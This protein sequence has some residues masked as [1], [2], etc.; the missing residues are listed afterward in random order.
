MDKFKRV[1]LIVLDSCGIGEAPDSA[2]FGDEGCSTIRT[3]SNSPEF[4]INTLRSLGYTHIDGLSFLGEGTLKSRVARLKEISKGKDTTIGHWEIAG[5]ISQKPLPT[6][7]NG[8]P[9]DLISEFEKRTGRRVICNKT[10]SGTEVIKDYGNEH[11]ESGALIVYTSADSV[12]QIAAHE[13]IVPTEQLYNYCRIAREML[14][15]EWGIGRVIARPFEGKYPFKRTANR[16]DFSLEPPKETV[17]DELKAEGFDVIAVGKINDI[18]AG[19]GITEYTYTKNNTDGMNKTSEYQSKD[20]NGL[21]FINL[22]D[23]DMV[24]G[25]RND[26][27]GYARAFTE[28]DK[29]LGTFINNMKSD[30]ALIITADHGCD[31]GFKGTDHTREYVPFILY[32]KNIE[33]ENK[34]TIEGFDYISQQVKNLLKA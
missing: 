32:S 4:N 19:K 24:Y 5:V 11:L 6:F 22:V 27:N 10:Y 30:D 15:G 8:F 1:F 7:P 17:L 26:T 21:C 2:Y 29:W 33:P 18:F 20:F 34:G 12:F 16:H 25:H 23:F 28:F 31:P 14:V 9:D 3:I 13:D